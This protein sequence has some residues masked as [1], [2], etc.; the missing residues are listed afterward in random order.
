[1][2]AGPP[3]HAPNRAFITA[4]KTSGMGRM[5]LAARVRECGRQLFPQ[6]EPPSL[7]SVLKCINRIE[8][9][10]VRRPGGDF[11]APALAMAL[12][13]PAAELFGGDDSA[14]PGQ[15]TGF[16]V[17][18]HQIVPVFIGAECAER[19]MKDASFDLRD[20]E[21]T[22]IASR[23]MTHP[24]GMCTA[25][26]LQWGVV[27]FHIRHRL[28]LANVAALA[29]WRKNAHDTTFEQGA[30][31]IRELLNDPTAAGPEYVLS[32]FWV[33]EPMWS[34]SDLDTAMRLMCV[35]SVLLDRRLED[36]EILVAKAEVA[37]RAHLRSGFA[38]PD[39]VEFGV[40]GVSIGCASWSGVVYL[41]LSPARALQPE[42]FIS[43]EVVV[44]GLWCYSAHILGTPDIGGLPVRYGWRFLRSC[45]AHMT[46]VAPL[47]TGQ[48]RMMRDAVLRTSR[49]VEQLS[50][51]QAIL[52]DSD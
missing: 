38:H 12:G 4:R 43:F 49:L 11:Y 34:G 7:D 18:S 40:S 6:R 23:G 41:P 1:M 20:W 10:E 3:A 45:R 52:R 48:V 32:A 16:L 37:E 27:V 36:E 25:Y 29:T 46:A 5:K 17:V 26:A 35:P 21:W 28:S 30:A 24:T 50:Q 31:L 33:D 14:I 8:R 13:V 44:Q 47:E 42:E 15:D 9:G 51:A 2:T 19:L 22:R 39:I